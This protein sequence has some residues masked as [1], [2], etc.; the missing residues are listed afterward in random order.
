MNNQFN[1]VQAGTSILD[2]IADKTKLRVA[3]AKGIISLMQLQEQVLTLMEQNS[4]NALPCFEEVLR[5]PGLSF[6]CEVKKASPSKGIIAEDFPYLEI[7]LEYESAGAAAISILTE[8]EFFLG[9]NHYLREIAT[10]V[11]IPTLRKD[12]VIDAYQI[13]EAVLLGAKAVL[14][15]CA[16]L[17]EKTINSFIKI[18]DELKMSALVEIHNEEEAEQ[19]IQ[20]GA[21]IIGIN[22]RDLT[23]FSIDINTSA[24]LRKCIPA[25]IVTVA[26][27]GVKSPEDVRI[28]KDCGFDAV[29]IGESLMRS[30]DKKRFLAELK[31]AAEVCYEN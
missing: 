28:V 22:N 6:I 21:R 30:R 9:E 14:L 4:G 24:R 31:S 18:T 3:R 16:L 29:L 1:E 27:S 15:I 8:P 7:A 10:A 19:A 26:E 17:D 20:A 23:T 2:I 25:S 5:Q 12:F 11:K 13:Y